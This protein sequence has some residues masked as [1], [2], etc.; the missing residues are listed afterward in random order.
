MDNKIVD[1]IIELRKNYNFG[2]PTIAKYLIQEFPQENLT[3][4]GWQ[5]RID[6]ALKKVGLNNRNAPDVNISNTQETISNNI[7][8]HSIERKTDGSYVYEGIIE[9]LE[10]EEV[11]PDRMMEAHHLNPREWEV[12]SY[13]NNFWSQQSK[14]GQTVL[15][16]QSK[17]IVRPRR[18]DNISEELVLQHFLEAS[19]EH[20]APGIPNEYK[21]E[22]SPMM[23]EVNIC[24]LHLGKLAFDVTSNDM[25]NYKIAR[26]RFFD[27]IN[28]EYIRAKENNVEKILFVWSNDFFN[29]DGITDSTTRGTPQKSALPWQSLFL[30]G[31]SML[32]DAIE[33]LA[34]VA[35]VK[36]F[37]ISSNHSRQ[38]DFYALCYLQAWFRNTNNVQIINNQKSR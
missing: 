38:A 7:A 5:S 20:K 24:D 4:K 23:L 29:T 10:N 2:S 31:V 35:P 6:R 37:Y 22:N 19:I 33:I 27:L 32:V 14:G 30:E 3:L 28:K 18:F 34:S 1:R 25:Y 11:T 17:L 9:L 12:V 15:L 26:S 8:K 36:S 21:K 13:K 16:Y